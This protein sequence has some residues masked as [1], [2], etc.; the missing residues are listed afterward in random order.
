MKKFLLA[1]LVFVGSLGVANAQEIASK[2]TSMVNLGIGLGYRFGG[3]M[4]V[5]PLSVAY[6]YSLK[7]GLI[8]GNGAITLGGYLAYT[9]ANYSYWAQSTTASYT[10]LGVR[11]MFHYQ[12]VPKL[13]TYA[14]LML[15]Y[16][17]TSVSSTAP[18]EHYGSS[19]AA[20]AFDMGVILGARY[21]FTPRIGAFTELGYSL[22]YWNL[23]V[24]FKL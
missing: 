22:P 16:H 12:F 10:V 3:S 24:T 17:F 18:A 11:G 15:G 1:A 20:S 5:P 21:F 19:I 14:G 4:S 23:G 8:D 2:G 6:D 7:S 13:D 9:S